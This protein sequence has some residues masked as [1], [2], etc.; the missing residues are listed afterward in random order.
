MSTSAQLPRLRGRGLEL[1]VLAGTLD[2]VA[3]GRPAAAVVEGAAGIGKT[4][5]LAETL[6]GASARGF[7]VVT[8]RA[9]ELERTRP[10]GLLSDALACSR[11][12]PDPRRAAIAALL[13]TQTGARGPLTVT[14]DPGLPFQAIDAWTWW[15]RSRSTGRWPSAST[16]CSGL[17]RPAC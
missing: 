7:G 15:S 12:S 2:R 16:T 1:G 11:S 3:A 5:M 10:F 14:S 9:R 17:T 4:R 8:G 13:A 6:D